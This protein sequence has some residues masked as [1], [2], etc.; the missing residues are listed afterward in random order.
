MKFETVKVPPVFEPIVITIESIDELKWLIA[1]ANTSEREG[2]EH[3]ESLGF[4]MSSGGIQQMKLW[5]GLDTYRG[6]LHV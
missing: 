3:A 2:H 6:L 1:I 5:N 4:R